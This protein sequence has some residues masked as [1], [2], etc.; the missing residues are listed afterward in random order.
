MESWSPR[1]TRE[2]PT[3]PPPPLQCPCTLTLCCRF[4]ISTARRRSWRCGRWRRW[5]PRSRPRSGACGRPSNAWPPA[6]RRRSP[7]AGRISTRT[8]PP[9]STPLPSATASSGNSKSLSLPQ[10]LPLLR[11]QCPCCPSPPPATSARC[12]SLK[13]HGLPL[14][15]PSSWRFRPLAAMS[16]SFGPS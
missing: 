1:W 14:F 8:S 16:T 3:P 6:P 5:P 13:N 9:S 2:T 12:G 4:R 15:F 10:R 7:S 11:P